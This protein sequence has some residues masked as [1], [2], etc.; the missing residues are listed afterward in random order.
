M[1]KIV[2]VLEV[3]SALIIDSVERRQS[4]TKSCVC[5]QR[6]L[7]GR[8]ILVHFPNLLVVQP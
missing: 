6:T 1:K 2:A 4:S 7:K 3:G 8:N 5:V